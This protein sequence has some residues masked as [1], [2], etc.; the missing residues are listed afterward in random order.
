MAM[1][2]I[3]ATRT[4]AALL[5][6]GCIFGP[7]FLGLATIAFAVSSDVAALFVLGLAIAIGGMGA[8][9]IVLWA[10]I[11]KAQRQLREA[12]DAWLAGDIARAESLAACVVGRVFRPD[13]HTGAVHMLGLCAEARAEWQDAIEHFKRA[14]GAAPLLTLPPAKSRARCLAGAHEV[15]A[16]T[17]LRRT[18]EARPLYVAACAMYTQSLAPLSPLASFDSA[19]GAASMHVVL[20]SI[21]PSRDPRAVLALAGIFL[22]HRDGAHRQAIDLVGVESQTLAMRLLPHERALLREID[23]SSRRAL[24]GIRGAAAAMEP[25]DAASEQWVRAA[26][27]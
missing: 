9:C 4:R 13:Y 6:F 15:I 8:G 22:A 24:E 17:A 3:R 14:Q 23:Q 5:T 16:L 11:F 12:N 26:L 10:F 19:F 20:S 21:E 2:R 1:A 7:L 25:V 27:Y 18:G